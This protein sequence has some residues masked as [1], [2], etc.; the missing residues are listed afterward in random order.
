MEKFRT[1]PKAKEKIEHLLKTLELTPEKKVEEFIKERKHFFSTKCL[2]KKGKEVFIKTVL[3]N[4]PH[5]FESLKREG[6]LLKFFAKNKTLSEKIKTPKFLKGA[7]SVSF[8]WFL[9]QFAPGQRLGEFYD[10]EVKSKKYIKL[11]TE[12]LLTIQGLSPYYKRK[13]KSEIKLADIGCWKYKKILKRHQ[14]ESPKLKRAVDFQK[15]EKFF[16]ENYQYLQKAPIVLTHGDFTFSNHIVKGNQIWLTDWEWVRFD[17]FCVDISH[18]WIQS[19]RYPT[20]QR[21]LLKTYLQEL[22]GNLKRI[23]RETFKLM[24]IIQA[25]NELRWNVEICPKKYKKNA[26]KF[27]LNTIKKVLNKKISL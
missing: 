15:V 2:T 9:H 24:A 13:I 19:W 7:L 27:C 12:N 22:N 4:K 23:F 1:I 18:L 16:E 5:F 6:K 10:L 3:E 8:P 17:N 11:L 25:L 26:T 14:R 20:W 21:L